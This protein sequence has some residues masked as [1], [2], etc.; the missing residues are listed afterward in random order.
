M[1]CG[2]LLPTCCTYLLNSPGQSGPHSGPVDSC[3]AA[4]MA[5]VALSDIAAPMPTRPAG[6]DD[7]VIP[8]FKNK[9]TLG[10]SRRGRKPKS[11]LSRA[12]LRSDPRLH[13]SPVISERW[14]KKPATA[15]HKRWAS[16][17]AGMLPAVPGFQPGTTHV[18][19]RATPGDLRRVPGRMPCTAGNLPALPVPVIA[20]AQGREKL[21]DTRL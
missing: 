13:T 9:R 16:G 2:W 17:R 5:S 19:A 18:S 20:T 14:Y 11:A 4:G 8:S 21:R 3:A 7:C 12:R 15:I 10:T 6:L 1:P